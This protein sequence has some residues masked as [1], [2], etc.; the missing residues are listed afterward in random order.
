MWRWYRHAGVRQEVTMRDPMRRVRRVTTTLVL[1]LTLLGCG[2]ATPR[3]Q[4]VE[5][6][7]GVHPDAC[8]AGGET[9]MAGRLLV[10]PEYGTSFNDR[11]VMWPVGFTGVRVDGE[12]VVLNA[13]GIVA[14]R[15]GRQYYISIAPVADSEKRRLMESTN[16]YPAAVN[17]DYA[18][19]FIDCT[20]AAEGAGD[21]EVAATYCRFPGE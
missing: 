15:T 2:S 14:A 16:A 4:P 20:A 5:L 8:Y 21:P 18:W 17:C 12:V 13:A 9:G 7:T 19:D 11:P 10:D 3:G 6:L 1:T